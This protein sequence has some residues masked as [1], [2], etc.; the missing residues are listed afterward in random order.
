MG[1]EIYVNPFSSDGEV[2]IVI[3]LDAG[4]MFIFVDTESFKLIAFVFDSILFQRLIHVKHAT[5]S[6]PSI[7]AGMFI[8]VEIAFADLIERLL[9]A[10]FNRMLLEGESVVDSQPTTLGAQ[11]SCQY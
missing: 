9:L 5:K 6:L 4:Q 2:I 8:V 1:L 11:V 7:A 10:N 3:D